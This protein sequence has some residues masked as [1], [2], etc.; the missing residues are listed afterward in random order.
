MSLTDTIVAISTATGV[1]AISIVRLSGVDAIEIANKAT[2]IDLN[3]QA[4]HS[5]RY[6]KFLHPL[7]RDVMDE[8][9]ISV[10]RAPKTYT[11]EDIVEINCHGG[12]V[13]TRQILQSLLV[14]G[15]RLALPGEFTQRAYL[16][17]RIDLSQAEATMDLIDAN[18]TLATQ[19]AIQAIGG[20]VSKLLDPLLEKMMQIV[21]HI[22]VNI[23]YPEY[24]DVVEMTQELL[25][26]LAYDVKA[27]LITIL[28]QAE[29]GR[30]IK[31]GVKSVILGKPNVGKSSLLN[32]LLEE[33]KAIVTDI[34][35]T[36]R[37]L[38]EGWVRLDSIT[39]HLIDTAGIRTTVDQIEQ[40]GIDKSFQ[41]LNDAELVIVLL[42]G[43]QKLTQ[44]DHLILEKTEGLNRIVVTNKQD[45]LEFQHSDLVISAQ[46]HQIQSLI[47]EINQR[48]QDSISLLKQPLLGNQRQ[49]A[50]MQQALLYLNQA[51]S[52]V[53]QSIELDIVNEDFVRCYQQLHAILSPAGSIDL[54]SE[55]FSRFCLGK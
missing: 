10:F 25:L 16:N 19:A 17:G 42:D 34:A 23:D 7:T 4:S 47:E 35:G 36:T 3:L 12:P 48:Y 53:E 24:D 45:I 13:I 18:S 15:A 44:E 33:D 37:D 52:A 46:D 11:R 49:V 43:S 40:I 54:V 14:Y 2:S 22:E 51:L 29:T 30:L 38:V 32:A 9:M 55:I 28:K 5:I 21:T 20:S 50:H 1:G 8:V 6:G 41:A 27:D 39:L 26:P 31:E